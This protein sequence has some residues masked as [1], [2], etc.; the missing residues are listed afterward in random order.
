[1]IEKVT[2]KTLIKKATGTWEMAQRIRTLTAL[3][4]DMC[5]VPRTTGM[6]TAPGFRN[7]IPSSDMQGLPYEYG[8]HT[9]AENK[10]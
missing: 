4:E 7:L 2:Q 3:E 9:Y 10:Y 6:L 1:M 5:Q 8:I